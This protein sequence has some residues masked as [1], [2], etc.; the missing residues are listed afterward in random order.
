MGFVELWQ[1]AQAHM[2]GRLHS[3]DLIHRLRM[4]GS[5]VL[6]ATVAGVRSH[7]TTTLAHM[8]HMPRLT[9]TAVLFRHIPFVS[10]ITTDNM[11]TIL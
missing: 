2:S 10:P 11:F 3:R 4:T 9:P 8:R 1:A 7:K 5:L 6:V